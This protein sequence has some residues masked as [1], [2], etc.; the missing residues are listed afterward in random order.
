MKTQSFDR[1][2]AP[3]RLLA[4]S[5]R[6]FWRLLLILALCGP[7]GSV[8]AN[9]PSPGPSPT[10]TTLCTWSFDDTAN[11]T[12]DKGYAPL[13]FTNLS[14]SNLGDQWA[15]VVDSTNA[16][17]L[18]YNL[19]E[20]DGSTNLTLS[21]GTVMFWFAPNWTDTNSGGTG[22]GQPGR[23]VEAGT[24]T[25]N[26]SVGWWSLWLSSD[27]KSV[28]F[29]AQTNGSGTTYISAPI[30]WSM[31]NRWHMLTLTYSSTNTALYLDDGLVTNG[32][33][34]TIWPGADVLTNGFFVG[35]DSSGVAQVHGLIDDLATYDYPVASN[36]V[37]SAFWDEGFYF[38]AN[39]MNAANFAPA[40][41]YPT[42][43][44]DFNVISGQGSLSNVT[45]VTCVSGSA[46]WMTNV[47][48]TPRSATVVD[49]YFDIAGSWNGHNG[50][51]DVFAN[52]LLGPTNAP[53]N[54]WVWMGQGYSCNRYR[55]SLTNS[56]N[57]SGF[58]IL[59]T[60]QDQD[61]D[62]LTDAYELLVSH[63]SPTNMF[64]AGDGIPD[65]WKVLWGINATNSVASQDPDRDALSNWQEYL[66][67]TNP[68]LNDGLKPWVGSP[69]TTSGIP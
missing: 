55:L 62:G 29:T 2:I 41:S 13:S 3:A 47:T 9:P 16:A 19:N 68:T 60:P 66:W 6:E 28:N 36:A 38:Y 30:S 58:L 59:G 20:S 43:T 61:G 27:G 25:T 48:A 21:Q 45:T 46:V 51:F 39:P 63:T 35:S 10:N 65:G 33:P 32:P 40:G 17:W 69:A 26:A 8:H 34:M 7:V 37:A 52:T 49:V 31:T 64:S 5:H 44:P 12:S 14:A 42:N 53:A 15:V 67:G 24:Y 56:P 23:F 11:W 54:Q 4:P 22:P 57:W 18:Q 50:P 1:A